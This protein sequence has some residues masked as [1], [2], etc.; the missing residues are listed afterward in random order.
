MKQ[1]E[2]NDSTKHH[3]KMKQKEQNNTKQHLNKTE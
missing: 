2:Q 1:N 3:S